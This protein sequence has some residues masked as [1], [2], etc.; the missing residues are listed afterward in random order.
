M[1][2]NNKR[3]ENKFYVEFMILVGFV[4]RN[5]VKRGYLKIIGINI[6]F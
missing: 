2:G 1:R 4:G 5:N 6:I 3:M